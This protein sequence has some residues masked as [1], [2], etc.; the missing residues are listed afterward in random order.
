MDAIE[1][2]LSFLASVGSVSPYVGLF[3]T[4]WGIMHAFIGLANLTQ[5]SL[6]TVAPGIAEALVATAIG[7]FSGDPGSHRVQPLRARHRPHRHQA[8]NLHRRVFQQSCNAHR[9]SPG[10]RQRRAAAGRSRCRAVRQSLRRD[11]QVL[12]MAAVRPTRG[13]A[14]PHHQRDQHGAVHRRHA[15]PAYHLHGQRAV[16]HHRR[17]QPAQR[18]QEPAARRQ[19][20]RGHRRADESLRVKS[21]DGTEQPS[22]LRTFVASVR[23][24][25]GGDPAA[26]VVISGD[27]SVKYDVV[28]KVMNELQKAG[29]QR[30]ALS[31][32]TTGN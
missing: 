10:G 26:P 6:A 14:P 3:G 28:V 11:H 31:V 1:S 20:G 23:Q 24:A 30:V 2:H 19:G 16:D 27:K 18:R 7:L 15:G 17:G 12:A 9:A 21:A 22:S 25:Q 32:K 5:V 4:V 8:R 13:V 29:V